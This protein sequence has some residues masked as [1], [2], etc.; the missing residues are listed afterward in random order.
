MNEFEWHVQN[1]GKQLRID[2][3]VDCENCQNCFHQ[4]VERFKKLSPGI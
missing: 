2:K 3:V 4:N 1:L